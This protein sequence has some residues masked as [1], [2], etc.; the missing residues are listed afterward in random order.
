MNLTEFL[1]AR[2]D[3]DEAV[4]RGSAPGPWETMTQ[5]T[6]DG[7]NVYYTVD[8]AA[9]ETIAD[10]YESTERGR[11]T[12]G[13]V[14]RYSPSRVLAE[15]EAKRRIV[16]YREQEARDTSMP[17]MLREARLSAFDATLRALALPYADHP[18]YDEAWR[19]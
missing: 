12:S 9:G 8:T 11:V 19:V 4:A 6:A 5:E 14:A 13:H 17:P 15:C 2:I 7:E 1:T 16:D 18:D 10:L 3:E